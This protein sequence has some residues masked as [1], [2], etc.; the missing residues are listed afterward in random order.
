MMGMSSACDTC[1]KEARIHIGD[2]KGN[3]VANYC[4]D[5]HNSLIAVLT[6]TDLPIN[7]PNHI[8]F[9]A[10]D[11][12]IHTF[13]IELML[14]PTC[15]TLEAREIGETKYKTDVFGEL[16]DDFAGMWEALI[17]QIEKMLSVKYMEPDGHFIGSKA[18]GY[19]EYNSARKANDIIIDGRPYTWQELE[20][21][22][23]AHEGYKIK[24][25]F[26]DIGDVLE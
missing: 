3:T 13:E 1:G 24:V 9:I 15:K 21:N 17:S 25:E 4:L 23:S 8:S 12:V 18:V 14:H 6:D 16:D 26:G 5:C 11:G 19:I 7:I 10:S 2:G 20:Q 22:I